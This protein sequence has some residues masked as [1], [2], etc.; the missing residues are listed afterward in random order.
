MNENQRRTG[1]R[2]AVM[3]AMTT[4]H[5]FY[6]SPTSARGEPANPNDPNAYVTALIRSLSLA[7]IGLHRYEGLYGEWPSDLSKQVD[8]ASRLMTAAQ[9]A[10]VDYRRAAGQLEPYLKSNSQFISRSAD[11]GYLGYSELAEAEQSAS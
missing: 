3:I 6:G 8:R 1:F 5:L 7:K 4:C 11:M 9:L 10:A 2:A